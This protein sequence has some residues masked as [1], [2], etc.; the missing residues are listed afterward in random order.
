MAYPQRVW[1]IFDVLYLFSG[2]AQA[3][4]SSPSAR[5]TR[6]ATSSTQRDLVKTSNR[7]AVNEAQWHAIGDRICVLSTGAPRIVRPFYNTAF[8]SEMQA[9]VEISYIWL[10]TYQIGV[11]ARKPFAPY[12]VVFDVR[13]EPPFQPAGFAFAIQ[14]FMDQNDGLPVDERFRLVSLAYAFHDNGVRGVLL[15]G[16]RLRHIY[17][18]IRQQCTRGDRGT[19]LFE[20]EAVTRY[21]TYAGRRGWHF[22]DDILAKIAYLIK[23]DAEQEG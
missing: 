18:E 8:Y 3:R 2:V 5:A 11:F 10:E 12:T 14:N 17:Y 7:T 22:Y 1:P 21:P 23:A 15:F 13:C 4:R 20:V 9:R 6:V 16:K 19:D